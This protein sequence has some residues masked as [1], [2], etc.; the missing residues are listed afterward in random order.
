[1]VASIFRLRGRPRFVAELTSEDLAL[2]FYDSFYQACGTFKYRDIV[3]LS[4]AL[5]VNPRTIESWKYREKRPDFT[6][7]LFVIEWIKQGK[8]M[9]LESQSHKARLTSMV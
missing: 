9:R 4:R 8:P 6:K 3:A 2:P 5:D 1:M 7:M